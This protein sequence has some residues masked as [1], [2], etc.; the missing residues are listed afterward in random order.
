MED[1]FEKET[2]IRSD[3]KPIYNNNPGGSSWSSEAREC[4]GLGR[5]GGNRL[6][7]FLSKNWQDLLMVW[8]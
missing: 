8:I 3:R 6:E 4:S 5:R 2:A 1:G 7:K